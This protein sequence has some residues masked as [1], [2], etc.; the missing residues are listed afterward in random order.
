MLKNLDLDEFVKVKSVAGTRIGLFADPIGYKSLSIWMMI[1]GGLFTLP[2]LIGSKFI[3]F[4]TIEALI[5]VPLF[6]FGYKLYKKSPPLI[7]VFNK[8]I[9]GVTFQLGEKI[10]F[11]PLSDLRFEV[12][13]VTAYRVPKHYVLR[14]HGN[15]YRRQCIDIPC[16]GLDPAPLE[17]ISMA[18]KEFVSQP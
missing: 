3:L 5:F 16:S 10:D 12:H 7:V 2:A 9:G 13:K 8:G 4:R 18:L 17:I 11:L 6:Y 1:V 15:I 14:L